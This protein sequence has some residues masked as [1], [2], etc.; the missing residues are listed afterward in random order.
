M[1]WVKVPQSREKST[2]I[3][4]DCALQ[5]R[6]HGSVFDVR[7]GDVL[8][9][10]APTS[11]RTYPVELD[12]HVVKVSD[13]RVRDVQFGGGVYGC[14]ADECRGLTAPHFA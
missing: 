6:L 8:N 2:T 5:C 7:T 9:P 14:S 10:P 13:N 12:G 1:C 11:V 3:G 4:A